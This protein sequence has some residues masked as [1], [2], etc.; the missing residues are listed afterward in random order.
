MRGFLYFG[1]MKHISSRTIII[2]IAAFIG[3]AA[4]IA[5]IVFAVQRTQTTSTST[6][7]QVV[8]GTN[9]WGDIASQVGGDNVEVTSILSDPEVDP[10]LFEADAKTASKL[11]G[12]QLVIVNGL[13]YDEF[14]D[15]LLAAAPSDKTVLTVSEV[16][17]SSA[18]A[19]PHLW[20]DLPRIQEV[21]VAIQDELIKIDSANEAEYKANTQKFIAELQPA[22]DK[23]TEINSKF[24]GKGVAYTE[25]VAE[26]LVQDAGL[27]DKTPA[28][29]AAAVEDGTDPSPQQVQSFQNALTSGAVAVL[30]YNSQAVNEMT[31]QVQATAKQANVGVVGVGETVPPGKTFQ[32]WQLDQLNALLVALQK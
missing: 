6:K 7:V 19:N 22:I 14:M 10:H 8:A 15:K 2:S 29:F 32:A 4:L 12:A 27:V 11:S 18:D 30:L 20:Y 13:G 5:G 9:V 25:R 21:A 26:Y 24:A 3:A 1:T 23:L 16:L 28:D 17:K 31:E